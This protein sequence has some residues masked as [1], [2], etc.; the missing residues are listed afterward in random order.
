MNNLLKRRFSNKHG[1]S[2]RMCK[3]QKHHWA[4]HRKLRDIKADVSTWEQIE[5]LSQKG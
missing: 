1:A 4:D 2:C 3:P 5:E